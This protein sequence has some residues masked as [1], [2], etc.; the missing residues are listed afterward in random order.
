MTEIFKQKGEAIFGMTEEVGQG[1]ET[2]NWFL[3]MFACDLLIVRCDCKFSFRIGKILDWQ[4]QHI[5]YVKYSTTLQC[6]SVLK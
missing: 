1:V 5:Y 4:E 3:N 2:G 6:V